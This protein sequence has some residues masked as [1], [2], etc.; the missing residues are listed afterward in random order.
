MLTSK[1]STS[2]CSLRLTRLC[3][4][5]SHASDTHTHLWIAASSQLLSLSRLLRGQVAVV[6]CGPGPHAALH[7]FPPRLPPPSLRPRQG[8]RRGRGRGEQEVL[9]G[10]QVVLLHRAV[11]VALL[12]GAVYLVVTV[13]WEEEGI[14]CL[15]HP[16]ILLLQS[17]K[18]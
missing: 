7:L 6:R 13:S 12:A 2:N 14:L 11:L 3:V 16:H 15:A 18:L 9:T 1:I 5:N 17:G 8:G 10:A 4:Y